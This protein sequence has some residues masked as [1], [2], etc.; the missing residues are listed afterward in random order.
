MAYD[1]EAKAHPAV[2]ARCALVRLAEAVEDVRQ[3]LRRD[4][5]AGVADRDLNVRV[6]ALQPDLYP[7]APRGKLN[8]VREQIPDHLL[9]A[10][11]VARD[12]DDARVH[13]LLQAHA[14]C[15][16][17][18]TDRFDGCLDER[19]W[20]HLSDVYPELACDDA[21]NIEQVVNELRLRTSVPLYRLKGFEGGVAAV[22][23]GT[24]HVRPPQD[25]GQRRAQLVRDGGEELI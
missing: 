6:H 15:F 8:G 11:G 14:L 21:R 1:G 17:R 5:D 13:D 19:I 23:S 4:P 3:K 22:L 25:G 2:L 9:K 20:V 12:G 24:Q 10:H 7:P 18:G 16:R